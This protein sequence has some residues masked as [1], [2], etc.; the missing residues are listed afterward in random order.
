MPECCSFH[1]L[2][3]WA[4]KRAAPEGSPF[5]HFTSTRISCKRCRIRSRRGAS[6]QWPQCH[7]H[8]CPLGNRC[9]QCRQTGKNRRRRSP[10]H[11]SCSPPRRH[12]RE[13]PGSD[14][15]HRRS[16][17]GS[18]SQH[19]SVPELASLAA[20]KTRQM[21][22]TDGHHTVTTRRELGV[23]RP[24]MLHLVPTLPLTNCTRKNRRERWSLL[25]THVGRSCQTDP[26]LELPARATPVVSG[27]VDSQ[28]HIVS[29]CRSIARL[30]KKLAGVGT[31]HVEVGHRRSPEVL[32]IFIHRDG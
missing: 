23:R 17:G 11:C 24:L 27:H 25:H 8:R 28:S 14:K 22:T 31:T 19:G 6:R 20:S 4:R 10:R 30:E 5:F 7:H 21:V 26:N 29:T 12:S 32:P 9:F 15:S 16:C 13:P 1:I 2:L 3:R 18:N